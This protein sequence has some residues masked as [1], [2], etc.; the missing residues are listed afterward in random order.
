MKKVVELIKE[1]RKTPRGKAILFFAFYLVFFLVLAIFARIN[2]GVREVN[3]ESNKEQFY[4]STYNGFNYNYKYTINIDGKV[5]T[6]TGKKK[7]LVEEFTID[8]GDSK[9][10]YYK[11]GNAYYKDNVTIDA[12]FP[13]V[14]IDNLDLLVG[15]SYYESTTNYNSGKEVLRYK[16]SSDTIGNIVNGKEY[17]VEEIPNDIIITKNDKFIDSID[18]VLNSYCTLSN[19]CT[20]N[21]KITM[22]FY[23]FG[24]VGEIENPIS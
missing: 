2:P 16:I 21:M 20:N 23:D 14:I 15:F 7:D 19:T 5:S 22:D 18:L 9:E 10:S 6:I 13:F 12:P 1:L 17:D 8:Y 24:N 4:L 11:S 3:M